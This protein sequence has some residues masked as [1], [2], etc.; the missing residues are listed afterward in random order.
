[1]KSKKRYKNKSW[2][3]WDMRCFKRKYV[4]KTFW[5]NVNKVFINKIELPKGFTIL[6]GSIE[7]L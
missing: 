3:F 6:N 5:S 4:S 1:M 7:V 2:E